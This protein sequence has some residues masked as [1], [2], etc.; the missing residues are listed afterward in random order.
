M[1]NQ[2]LWLRI[3]TQNLIPLLEHTSA[4]ISERTDLAVHVR[5]VPL[6]ASYHLHQCILSSIDANEKGRYSVA[7]A[8]LRQC[9]ETLTI[10]EVGFQSPKFATN[11]ISGFSEGRFTQGQIR[12]KLES[13]I[14]NKY[15]V[16]L[17]SE[18]WSE[19]Y[20]NLA[21]AV[22]PYA[23]YS[24]TLMGWQYAMPTTAPEPKSVSEKGTIFYAQIGLDIKDFLKG[25]RV[26]LFITLIGWTIARLME[27]NKIPCPMQGEKLKEW[28][29]SIGS[30]DILDGETSSWSDVFLPYLWFNDKNFQL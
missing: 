9:V 21:R 16:G 7:M 20:G 27:E 25:A 12:Q 29:K 15:G 4:C 6:L 3:S 11:I 18:S 30:S 5:S 8:L 17:W 28:G 2:P 23:H 26:S 13:E 24:H 19:Y 22:Q 14:W 1:A 10:V